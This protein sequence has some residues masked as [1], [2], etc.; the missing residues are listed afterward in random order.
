MSCKTND[1]K[2][3]MKFISDTMIG[4]YSVMRNLQEDYATYHQNY[5]EEALALLSKSYDFIESVEA[6]RSL[7]SLS[8]IDDDSMDREMT[9]EEIGDY[10]VSAKV[11]KVMKQSLFSSLKELVQDYEFK[12]VVDESDDLYAT[13]DFFDKLLKALQN[14]SWK[15]VA[16]TSAEEVLKTLPM[17][18]G[19]IIAVSAVLIALSMTPIGLLVSMLTPVVGA[20][21][22]AYAGANVIKDIAAGLYLFTDAVI[23]TKE[24]KSKGAMEQTSALFT[25]AFEYVGPNLLMD[26]LMFFGGKAMKNVKGANKIEPVKEKQI[27]GKLNDNIEKSLNIELKIDKDD[28]TTVRTRLGVPKTETVAVGKTNV[29]GLEKITF[30]GQS[31]KVRKEAGLPDL[32]EVWR[33]RNIKAPGQNP[34]FTRHAEEVLANS[35]D[36]AV[37]EAK[38]KPED[39]RGVLKIHQSNPSGVCRKCIQGLDNDIVKPGVLKQ[40]SLKYP[41][42]RIEVTSEVL[43]N[44]KVSGKSNFVIMNGKYIQ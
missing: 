41:N 14:V 10:K 31:P 28:L 26:I 29:K 22:Q 13:M 16:A 8:S 20:V 30:E 37:I 32:D 23:Q 2:S 34:L 17:I 18:V 9:F 5:S 33:N 42:L 11:Y 43:P 12:V 25:K 44:V 3:K 6:V 24:A 39:V 35:F 15:E 40:L 1:R 19:T 21:M 36:K 27:F 7:D 4:F 38:I